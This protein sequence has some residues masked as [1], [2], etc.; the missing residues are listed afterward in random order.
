[1][2]I[3]LVLA[4]RRD[5]SLTYAVPLWYRALMAIVT[6]LLA[7]AFV[8]AGEAPGLVGWVILALAAAAALYEES[9]RFDAARGL[10][11]H[12][13]GLVIAARRSELSLAGIARF[14]VEAFVR[15]TIPGS[16]DEKA[17]NERVLAGRDGRE[18]EL[19]KRRP[20][21][22]K[23]YLRLICEAADGEDWL[24][25]MVPERRRA[26][27]LETAS[28]IATYCGKPLERG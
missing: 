17:E 2:E 14:R 13:A 10:A 9:W 1:M 27:I 22:K 16:E 21:Y 18:G 5:G 19:V 12:R 3:P 11:V 24:V 26:T 20:F 7:A 25:D 28:R 8:T 15:G 4:S 23:G 6:A